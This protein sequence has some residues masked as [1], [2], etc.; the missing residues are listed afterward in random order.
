MQD[1][2]CIK[3]AVTWSSAVACQ[4]YG[5]QQPNDILKGWLACT[6]VRGRVTTQQAEPLASVPHLFQHLGSVARSS[7]GC[8]SSGTVQHNTKAQRC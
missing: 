1:G 7:A 6:N 2:R 5:H 4:V 8:C 3:G